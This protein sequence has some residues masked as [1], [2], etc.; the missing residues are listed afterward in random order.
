MNLLLEKASR[1]GTDM[2]SRIEEYPAEPFANAVHQ[3]SAAVFGIWIFLATEVL[4]FGGM[5]V[6]YTVY[7]HEYPDAFRA[8]SR[9]LNEWTGGLMTAILLLGSLLIAVADRVMERHASRRDA[10]SCR[11]S[12]AWRLGVT[13]VLGILFLA[14]EFD[15]Y[16]SLISEGLFPGLRF[17]RTYFSAVELS[18][19][20][21]QVFFSLFFCMTGLHALHMIV[22]ISL[23]GGSAFRMW[24]SKQ[25]IRLRNSL[26]IVALYW[27]FVDIVWIFLYPLFYLVR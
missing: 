11:R 3:R 5:L 1:K 14:L 25:P 24:K 16:H 20:S 2:S 17:D 19:R 22:G 7:H 8:G 21:A 23:V 26:T 12:I 27:H 9:Y 10:T 18:G 15:E 6:A 13:A 4:F